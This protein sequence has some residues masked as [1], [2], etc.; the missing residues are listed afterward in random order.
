MRLVDLFEAR[1]QEIPHHNPSVGTLKA[2]ARANKY[3]SARF[4]IYKDGSVVAADSEHFTHHSA[5]P[6]MGAWALR[7]Y[8]QYLGD[9]DYAYRSME[10]YSP[11]SVDHPIFRVWERAGIENGNPDHQRNQISEDSNIDVHNLSIDQL[12]ELMQRN[13]GKYTFNIPRRALNVANLI[14]KG[15]IFVTYPH[16]KQGWKKDKRDWSYSLITLYNVHGRGWAAQSSQYKKPNSYQGAIQTIN[17]SLPNLGNTDLVYDN[18]YL[19]IL[20]SAKK[21]GLNDREIYLT[22]E[23]QEA[24]EKSQNNPQQLYHATL[25]DNVPSILHAGLTPRVGKIAGGIYK[26]RAKPLVFATDL[27]GARRCYC[28]LMSQINMKIGHMPNAEEVAQHGALLIISKDVD[29]FH[30]YSAGAKR[31]KGSIEP[32]DH[33]SEEPIR[34]DQVIKGNDLVKWIKQHQF[35]QA[36]GLPLVELDTDTVEANW[37]KK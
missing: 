6:A 14:R 13:Q 7:G 3:H 18:K 28:A 10:V 31:R 17:H 27:Q 8:V 1:F 33:Y 21:L 22:P 9:D 37:T 19:Q 11:T 16:S 29:K 26:D 35:D 30:Q 32:G 36:A 15:A 5:A 12:D 25:I 2:L 23:L 20:W 24:V 4:V 34:V